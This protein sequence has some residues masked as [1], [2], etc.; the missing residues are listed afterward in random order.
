[1]KRLILEGLI[2]MVHALFFKSKTNILI[3]FG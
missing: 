1:M 2:I 3:N